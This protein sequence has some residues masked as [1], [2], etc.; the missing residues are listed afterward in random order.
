[1]QTFYLHLLVHVQS[2]SISETDERHLM[3]GDLL[4]GQLVLVQSD[5]WEEKVVGSVRGDV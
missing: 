2:L 5:L 4:T 3:L 1:V